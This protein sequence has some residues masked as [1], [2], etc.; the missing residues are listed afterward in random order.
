MRSMW[1]PMEKNRLATPESNR[2]RPGFVRLEKP[3]LNGQQ[4]YERIQ[5]PTQI[6]RNA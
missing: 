4:V 1:L 5:V 3:G 6:V 2:L